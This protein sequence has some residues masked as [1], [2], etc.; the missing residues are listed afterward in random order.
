MH[1]FHLGSAGVNWKLGKAT[2]DIERRHLVRTLEPSPPGV[3]PA[4]G[5]ACQ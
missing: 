2:L 1:S 4:Q 3:E 5:K